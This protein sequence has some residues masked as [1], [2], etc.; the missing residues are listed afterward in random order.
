MG[1]LILHRQLVPH[2]GP[3]DRPEGQTDHDADEQDR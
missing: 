2:Q 1:V 3:E